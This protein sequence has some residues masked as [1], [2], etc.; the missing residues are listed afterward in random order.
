MDGWHTLE[1]T[2]NNHCHLT[3]AST[4]IC[5]F[6]RLCDVDDFCIFCFYFRWCC[7][8]LFVLFP[9]PTVKLMKYAYLMIND[10]AYTPQV[11]LKTH[12]FRCYLLSRSHARLLAHSLSTAQIHARRQ[13]HF[14]DFFDVIVPILRLI[15]TV[16][17]FEIPLILLNHVIYTGSL[18]TH[19]MSTSWY[20]H[21]VRQMK[22]AAFTWRWTSKIC[23]SS[24]WLYNTACVYVDYYAMFLYDTH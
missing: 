7:C 24:C 15:S 4:W 14:F 3:S 8:P 5:A 22:N 20:T 17:M 10:N 16:I 21:S 2:K 12:I 19:E 23:S 1:V 6:K 11:N 13:I 18:F 9:L